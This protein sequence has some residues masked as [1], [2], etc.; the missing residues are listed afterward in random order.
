MSNLDL[1]LSMHLDIICEVRYRQLYAPS[2]SQT[3][4]RLMTT[5]VVEYLQPID[6]LNLSRT[7]K[8][9]YS[10]FL[11]DSALSIWIRSCRKYEPDLPDCQLAMSE[12]A[13]ASL[14]CEQGCQASPFR[15]YIW[16]AASEL[17]FVSCRTAPTRILFLSFQT[18]CV[19]IV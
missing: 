4:C 8:S 13:Y 11:N 7:S 19:A 18:R 12:W 10:F 14:F 9:L 5:Q 3:I 17:P 16:A 2:T 15:I 6:L 1:L